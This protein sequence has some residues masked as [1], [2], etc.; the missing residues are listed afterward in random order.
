MTKTENTF[1]SFKQIGYLSLNVRVMEI[2]LSI[3]SFFQVPEG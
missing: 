3:S 1:S 2:Q